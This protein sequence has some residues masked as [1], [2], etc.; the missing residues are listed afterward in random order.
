MEVVHHRD[1]NKLNNT[2]ENLEVLLSQRHHT[3]LEHYQDREAR[4]ITHL[5]DLETW[6]DALAETSDPRS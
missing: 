6:I 5:F 4:G 3:V 1:G 2:P